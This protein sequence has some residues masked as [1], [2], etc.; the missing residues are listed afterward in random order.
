MK[1]I[2]DGSSSSNNAVIKSTFTHSPPI[3]QPSMSKMVGSPLTDITSKN[4]V[5][6]QN[7]SI[8]P[9]IDGIEIGMGMDMGMDMDMDMRRGVPE[10][11]KMPKSFQRSQDELYPKL[12]MLATAKIKSN[13]LES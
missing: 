1:G 6:S 9:L 7:K 4:T 2:S 12:G 11:P 13:S 8:L 5:Y 10:A 3:N